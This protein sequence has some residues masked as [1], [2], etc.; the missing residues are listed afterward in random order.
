MPG[1][2]GATGLARFFSLE[3]S[4][5]IIF[6]FLLP[7]LPSGPPLVPLVPLFYSLHAVPSTLSY[8][9]PGLLMD[10][11]S[12]KTGQQLYTLPVVIKIIVVSTVLLFILI[13][14]Y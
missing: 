2:G 9:T 11:T 7:V 5:I 12:I 1:G 6:L 8:P 3:I 4:H 14:N 13:L 10:I